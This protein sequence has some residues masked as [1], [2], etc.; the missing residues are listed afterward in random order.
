MG[1]GSVVLAGAYAVARGRVRSGTW[2]RTQWHVGAYA[3]WRVVPDPSELYPGISQN[4]F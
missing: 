1:L 4:D 2:A 3:K